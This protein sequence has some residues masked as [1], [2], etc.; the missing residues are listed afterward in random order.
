MV[1]RFCPICGK[2]TDLLINGLCIDCYRRENPLAKPKEDT[3]RVLVCSICGSIFYRGRWVK[4]KGV[5]EKIVKDFLEFKGK[6]SSI[7][8]AITPYSLHLGEIE[9][10]VKGKAS[11]LIPFEYEEVIKLKLNVEKDV[12]PTCR[13]IA[14]SKERAIIQ[15]R[16]F[17][18]G[19]S[20]E[21][22]K[23]IKDIVYQVLAKSDY[24]RGAVLDIE[25]VENGIDIK[26]TNQNLAKSIAYAI[27]KNFP[28]R[29]IETQKLIGMSSQGK[30]ITKLTIS[31]QI[32]TL[33]KGD[34][35]RVEDELYYVLS[36]SS[37]KVNAI[38][39]KD[40]SIK[41]ISLKDLFRKEFVVIEHEK[42]CGK[43]VTKNS[44]KIVVD[45]QGNELAKLKGEVEIIENARVPVVRIG[46]DV[47]VVY[48]DT[49]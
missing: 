18:T 10:R 17:I 29:L 1:K 28:S 41:S 7:D 14:M 5:L 8:V 23:Y 47:Y 20:K 30:P 34:V 16:G 42:I 2:E 46:N 25:E 24:H 31:V 11:E 45:D 40:M 26:V 37:S 3:L 39:L 32:I 6:I 35:I 49:C 38:S 48:K 12:C 4:G 22:I 36:V 9:V 33:K 15:V 21:Y 19:L 43:V 27:H 44:E 13:S